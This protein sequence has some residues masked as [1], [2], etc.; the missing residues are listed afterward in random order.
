MKTQSGFIFSPRMRMNEQLPPKK[1]IDQNQ[2][3]NSFSLS[4]DSEEAYAWEK[5]FCPLT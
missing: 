3:E 5:L 4:V 2:K 1:V